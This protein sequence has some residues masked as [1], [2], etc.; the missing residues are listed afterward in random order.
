MIMNEQVPCESSG[1]SVFI[2][3]EAVKGQK[4]LIDTSFAWLMASEAGDAICLVA[5]FQIKFSRREPS[6]GGISN[7]PH[8][9]M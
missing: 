4:S 7:C 5:L 6:L 9:E 3:S 8:L 2:L 1:F